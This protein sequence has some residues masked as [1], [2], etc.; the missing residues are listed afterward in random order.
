MSYNLLLASFGTSGN[1]S[2]LLTAGRKLRSRGH[3]VRVIAD[4]A[5]R[6]EVE[7]AG[8]DFVTWRRAPTGGAADPSDFSSVGDWLRQAIGDPAPAYA[9]DI[10]DEIR[11]VPTDALLAIDILFGALF[12]AEA[13]AIPYAVLS[14]HF[15]LRPLPGLPPC[16]AG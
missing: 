2:P 11:R 1:L 10:L 3:G 16:P 8:F 7:S 9:A 13:A 5:V 12:G 15:S 6:K 4:P 14:P